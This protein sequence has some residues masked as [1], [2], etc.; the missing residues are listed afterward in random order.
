MKS[1]NLTTT[2]GDPGEV[3]AFLQTRKARERDNQTGINQISGPPPPQQEAP[4]S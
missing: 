3:E 2:E 1:I 4:T